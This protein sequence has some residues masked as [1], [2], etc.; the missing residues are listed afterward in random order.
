MHRSCGIGDVP[1]RRSGAQNGSKTQSGS[2][3]EGEASTE[4]APVDLAMSLA[5]TFKKFLKWVLSIIGLCH[6]IEKV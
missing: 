2:K 4:V 6:I 3:T 5:K 1:C